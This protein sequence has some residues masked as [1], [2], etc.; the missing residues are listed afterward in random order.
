MPEQTIIGYLLGKMRIDY[1]L[2]ANGVNGFDVP[3]N[4]LNGDETYGCSLTIPSGIS[5][6]ANTR[7]DV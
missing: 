1:W 2:K 7:E 3:R 4:C 6:R 5:H